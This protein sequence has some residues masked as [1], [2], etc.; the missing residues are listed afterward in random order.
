MMHINPYE[1]YSHKLSISCFKDADAVSG[2]GG[3]VDT[4]ATLMFK[5]GGGQRPISKIGTKN[6][7]LPQKNWIL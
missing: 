2:G 4:A 3:K 5:G 1:L 6:F 7:V